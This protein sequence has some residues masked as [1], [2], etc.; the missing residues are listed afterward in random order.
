MTASWATRPA[1]EWAAG[2][3]R[4]FIGGQ[5]DE[6]KPTSSA[7]SPQRTDQ[8]APSRERA[9][10]PR[11]ELDALLD[12]CPLA[13]TEVAGREALGLFG[14]DTRQALGRIVRDGFGGFC[15][16][17]ISFESVV[18]TGGR[19]N[20]ARELADQRGAEPALIFAARDVDGETIDLGALGVI[21]MRLALLLGDAPALGLENVTTPHFGRPLM[22]APTVAAWLR[23]R[24][25]VFVIDS[26][27]AAR[28]LEN[29]GPFG[30]RDP[31][32]RSALLCEFV[33]HTGRRPRS[34]VENPR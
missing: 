15:T 31:A 5:P 9:P 24:S 29:W 34:L 28:L 30:V 14:I 20:F 7:S 3:P 2:G 11:S 1:A 17:A 18:F 33:A 12:A 16:D 4:A 25:A 8:S 19:F 10:F 32:F 23:D 22:I 27:R 6:R 13:A 21:S 26:A